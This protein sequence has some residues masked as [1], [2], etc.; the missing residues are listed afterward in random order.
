MSECGRP[1]ARGTSTES[2][3]DEIAKLH[4]LASRVRRTT[5]SGRWDPESALIERD[6][7]ANALV[8]VARALERQPLAPDRRRPANEH[9][10]VDRRLTAL[11]DSQKQRI[12]M[13]EMQLGEANR[14][15]PRRR[16]RRSDNQ[17]SLPVLEEPDGPKR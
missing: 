5:F 4:R 6:E 17:L 7:I 11:L 10:A 16:Q 12:A 8:G 13:L 15:R 1:A 3:Q 2:V 9:P 14:P